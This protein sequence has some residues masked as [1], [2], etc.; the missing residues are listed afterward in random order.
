MLPVRRDCGKVERS[1]GKTVTLAMPP[2]CP[3][4][5]QSR[6]G[7]RCLPPASRSSDRLSISPLSIHPQ[8]DYSVIAHTHAFPPSLPAN[9]ATRLLPPL[10]SL[11][12]FNHSHVGGRCLIIHSA[13]MVQ[14][15]PP[16]PTFSLADSRLCQIDSP[17]HRAVSWL[18]SSWSNLVFP[19][20]S[21]LSFSHWNP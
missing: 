19:A 20:F 5:S 18:D 7:L 13:Q 21:C 4:R 3:C 17:Q 11:E 16:F 12:S 1:C 9:A 14:L 2:A 10:L 8:A 6:R 15:P